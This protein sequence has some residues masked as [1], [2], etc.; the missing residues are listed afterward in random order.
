MEFLY[1]N[2]K[3]DWINAGLYGHFRRSLLCEERNDK[4]MGM[5]IQQA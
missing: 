3:T 4:V 2:D 1:N 5:F